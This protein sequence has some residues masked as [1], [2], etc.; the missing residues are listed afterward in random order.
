M[1]VCI[2]EPGQNQMKISIGIAGANAAASWNRQANGPIRKKM[3]F[4]QKPTKMPNATQSWKLMTRP[5]RITAGTVS[6]VM[7]GMV[8]IFTPMPVTS[9]SKL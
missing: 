2:N 4:E 9:I 3:R 5:P 8:V 6:E 1:V 7:M